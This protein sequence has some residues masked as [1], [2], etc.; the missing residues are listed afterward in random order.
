MLKGKGG[1][2]SKKEG[3]RSTKLVRL[4]KDLAEMLV[5]INEITGVSSAEFIDPLIRPQVEAEYKKILPAVN[6]RR[7]A[8]E[9]SAKFRK[10]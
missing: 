7:K 1:R 6:A 3:E 4:P 9:E 8:D 10:E 2:P 5:W